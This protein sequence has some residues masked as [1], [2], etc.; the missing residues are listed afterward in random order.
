MVTNNILQ[1][2]PAVIPSV[3]IKTAARAAVSA[4]DRWD[5]MKR[6]NTLIS[7]IWEGNSCKSNK[8]FLSLRHQCQDEVHYWLKRRLLARLSW[9]A[10]H[11]ICPVISAFDPVP[12]GLQPY[13]SRTKIL[14]FT[15]YKNH[16]PSFIHPCLTSSF[17]T[18][19]KVL[20][21]LEWTTTRPTSE[22]KVITRKSRILHHRILPK[23]HRMHISIGCY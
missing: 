18:H 22:P 23:T 17:E 13:P 19:V 1:I 4:A 7:F 2:A 8:W 5:P 16:Q 3:T 21:D 10:R 14:F 15:I 20:R 9:R 12:L 11:A 6:W